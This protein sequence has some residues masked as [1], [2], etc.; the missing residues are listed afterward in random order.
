MIIAGI[1]FETQ[2]DDATTTPVTEVGLRLLKITNL[3]E[4]SL[5]ESYSSLVYHPEYPPQTPEIVELTG[6]TD[7]MLKAQGRPPREVF[8]G[9]MP[10]IGRAD[11]VV[12][13]NKKFD[14]TVC[15]SVT[16]RLQ[17][18]LPEKRWLCLMDEVPYPKKFRCRKL[19]HLAFDH[20]YP[21]DRGKLH[22]ALDDVDLM[23]Q[24]VFQHYPIEE[25]LKYADEPW[26]IVSAQIPPPWTDG[27]VGK[28]QA[29]KRGYG[30]EKPRGDD[31]KTYSKQWVK[32]IKV[33]AVPTETAEAPFKVVVLG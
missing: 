24:F 16:T 11:L 29:S 25:V 3:G 6:I 8:E 27:G 20:G 10:Y 19:S 4:Y 9:L 22:R 14:E 31:S 28:A 30:W 1:D 17:L 32:R 33:S 21:V 26:A 12:A 5:G 2:H 15:R 13:Y 18:T 7:E 23:L